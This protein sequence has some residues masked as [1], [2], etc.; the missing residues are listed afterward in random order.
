MVDALQS[1][2][3]TISDVIDNHSRRRIAASVHC[4]EFIADL[5]ELTEISHNLSYADEIVRLS[6]EITIS[7]VENCSS[8]HIQSLHGHRDTI[9]S[10]ILGHLGILSSSKFSSTSKLKV[11]LDMC[12]FLATLTLK[13]LSF[14][15]TYILI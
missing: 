6:A 3:N 4:S 11:D 2:H 5:E 15:E 8:D 1:V 7:P 12:V 9:M 10:H 14:I 13:T